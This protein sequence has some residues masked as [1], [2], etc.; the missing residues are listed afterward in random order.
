MPAIITP[1]CLRCAH[2]R[3]VLVNVGY[4]CTAFGDKSIPPDILANAADHRLAY[5]G[6]GGIRFAPA[7]EQE[8]R[9]L[10]QELVG[11]TMLQWA[12]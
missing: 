6:D 2:F 3:G 9:E 10:Q 8:W 7:S 1:L 12:P 5:P 11:W 4:I